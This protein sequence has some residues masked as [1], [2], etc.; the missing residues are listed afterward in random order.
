MK[1]VEAILQSIWNQYYP[2]L[3]LKI[4]KLLHL[5]CDTLAGTP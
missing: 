5:N 2:F 3:R 1:M 4:V